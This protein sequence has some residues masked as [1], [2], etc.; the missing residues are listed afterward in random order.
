[1]LRRRAPGFTLIEVM[2]TV[3]IVGVLAV[4][5]TLA[6]RRWTR[7]AYLVEAQDMVSSIRSAEIAFYSENGAYLNVTT[8]VGVGH[9]YP[10]TQ[11]GAF[12]TAWGG[13]CAVCPSP[14]AWEALNVRASG[15]VA[16][17]YSCVAGDGSKNGSASGIGTITVNGQALNLSAMDGSPW[18]F[19]EADANMSGDGKSYQHV[20]GMS[21]TS[22]IYVD[23]EGN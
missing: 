8:G 4:L 5:A 7:S 12:K 2:I 14:T 3:A 1:M 21:G 9:S 22:E 18:F 16:F 17:G 13:P 20:Y 19:V 15:P 10:A 11:P 6:Y 23:G